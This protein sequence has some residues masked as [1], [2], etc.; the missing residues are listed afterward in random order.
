[1][2]V[3]LLLKALGINEYGVWAALTS[4]IVW[5]NLFDFG[6]GHALKNTVSKSIATKRIVDAKEEFL[7]VFKISF[8]SSVVIAVIFLASLTFVDLLN[9]NLVVSLILFLPIILFFPLRVASFVLQGARRIALDACLMFLNTLLFFVIVA[10]L[11]FFDISVSLIVLAIAFVGSYLFS[12]IIGAIEAIKILEL[13]SGDFKRLFG[14]KLDLIRI[15][16]GLK[17]FGLQLSSLVLYSFG[18][19]IVFSFLSSAQA[20][21]F[22]VVSKIFVFGLSFFTIVIGA[23]WPEIVTHI[24]NDNITMIRRLYFRMTV[25][26]VIFSFAALCVAYFSPLII[27]IW[28]DTKIEVTS[29]ETIFFA[30]LVSF[31]SFAYSGAVVLNAFEKIDIQLAL[32]LAASFLMIPLSRYFINMGYG[33]EAIPIVSSIFTFFAMV[34]CNVHAC[35]ILKMGHDL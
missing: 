33:I 10:E 13:K 14:V 11:C 26:A 20:A 12:I 3:P 22:D 25:L 19:V 34:Y 16:L 15:I 23:F 27:Q 32:S 8:I 29:S 5:M 17:F 6:M 24:A 4:L 9:K 21:Q 2:M 30:I 7:Q 35:K 1:M 31:Q 28:T 18:T